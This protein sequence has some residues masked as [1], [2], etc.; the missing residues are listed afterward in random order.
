VRFSRF[1]LGLVELVIEAAVGPRWPGKPPE[2]VAG[3]IPQFRSDLS[4]VAFKQSGANKDRVPSQECG[5][6]A[7]RLV[8]G[9]ATAWATHLGLSGVAIFC[10]AFPFLRA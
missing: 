7:V 9:R 8:E 3:G 2:A 6:N 10:F 1:K 4:S 5:R